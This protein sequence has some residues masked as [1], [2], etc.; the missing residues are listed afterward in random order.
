MYSPGVNE[1]LVEREPVERGLS[2]VDLS[3]DSVLVWR[4]VGEVEH[5]ELE[6]R[7]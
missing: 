6:G 1:P 2:G 5:C 4:R 3:S 7:S